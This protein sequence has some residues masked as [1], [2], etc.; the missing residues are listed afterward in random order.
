MGIGFVILPIVVKYQLPK[1][2]QCMS[3]LSDLC[4]KSVTIAT[5]LEQAH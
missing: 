1:L 3:D 5:S 4:H 2:R